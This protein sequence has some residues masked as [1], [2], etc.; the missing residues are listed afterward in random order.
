MTRELGALQPAILAMYIR[1][2]PAGPAESSENDVLTVLWAGRSPDFAALQSSVTLDAFESA[3]CEGR[4]RMLLGELLRLEH[5]VR[6]RY[7]HV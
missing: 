2:L 5:T 7:A 4:V 3:S 1:L 6:F